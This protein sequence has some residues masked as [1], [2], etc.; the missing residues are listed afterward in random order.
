[1]KKIATE[2]KNGKRKSED[3][4]DIVEGLQVCV[5]PKKLKCKKDAITL[6][7]GV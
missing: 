6:H 2:I 4:S 7:E 3:I 1:M 5:E